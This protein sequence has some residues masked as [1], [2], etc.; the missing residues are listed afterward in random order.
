VCKYDIHD[1]QNGRDDDT[2]Y[3]T[4]ENGIGDNGEGLVNDHVGEEEGDEEEMAICTDGLDTVRVE[5]LFSVCV[6]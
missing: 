6:E 2:L 4:T 5:A 3:A 1:D